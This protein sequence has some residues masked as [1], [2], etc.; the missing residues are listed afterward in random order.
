VEKLDEILRTAVD[1]AAAAPAWLGDRR[2]AAAAVVEEGRLPT[3]SDEAWKYTSLKDIS[4]QPYRL[5]T[6]ADA[7][8]FAEIDLTHFEHAGSDGPFAV[9]V[10]GHLRADLSRLDNLP[11]GV[12][13]RTLASLSEAELGP[14]VSTLDGVESAAFSALNL[15]TFGDGLLLDVADGASATN[16]I[17]LIFVADGQAPLLSAPRIVINAGRNSSV[18]VIEQYLSV[19]GNCGLT[20]CVTNIELAE[21]ACVYHHRLQDEAETSAHIGRIDAKVS[22]NANL[23]SDSVAFGGRLTRVD[24][25]VA[26]AGRGARCRLNGLFATHGEQHIDHHTTV[27]HLVGDTHSEEL[28]RG[29]LDGHSRGVFNGK[30]IVHRDAQQISARQA[31]NNLLLSR[32]AEIDTKPELE[33]YADDVTCAHGATVGNLDEGALFYLRSRGIGNAEARALLTYAFAEQV[34][35]SIP[36]DSVRRAIE[37]RFIGHT[38]MSTLAQGIQP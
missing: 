28:Y 13:L 16:P 20:N 8:G 35:E 22:S 30:V 31:S 11:S 15:A 19:A 25:E 34:I 29:I 1:L 9:I 32:Q 7:L 33:I 26:L 38:D 36:L 23:H 24:I 12:T 10:N 37:Q 3:T 5:A 4:D 14:L 18:R 27:D 17:A 21:G 2:R 6:A